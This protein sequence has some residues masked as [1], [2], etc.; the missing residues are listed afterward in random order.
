MAVQITHVRLSTNGSGNEAIT[1]YKWRNE[2][3]GSTGYT[4]KPEMVA[5]V[6]TTGNS[7]YVDGGSTRVAVAV[8]RPLQAAAYLR[9]HA[10]GV[11]T[12]NLLSLPRF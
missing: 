3:N 6:D 7:A 12:D 8:V 9:T 4:G 5:W 1:H 10:N 2:N 11:W